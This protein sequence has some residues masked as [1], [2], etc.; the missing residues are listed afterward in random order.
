MDKHNVFVS[1]KFSD[2]VETRDKIID[3]LKDRGHVYKGEKGI[4]PLRVADLTLKQYLSDMI[5]NT[6]VTIVII[7]PE[8]RFSDWVDW[9]IRYSLRQTS[10]D[11]RQSKRNGIVCVIQGKDNIRYSMISGQ[12]IHYKDYNWVYQNSVYSPALSKYYLPKAII[13]N[14]GTTFPSANTMIYGSFSSFQQKPPR[15]DYCVFVNEDD[16]VNNPDKYI[17]EA[18]NR[19]KDDNYEVVVNE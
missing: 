7:S 1:Y 12:L 2:A 15:L 5:Y 13:D 16:F 10:R 18:F 11:G 4:K 14:M 19:S 3:V 8:V 17:N 6:T 9:E